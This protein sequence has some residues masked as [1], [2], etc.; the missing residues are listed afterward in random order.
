MQSAA[1]RAELVLQSAR[2][3]FGYRVE[4]AAEAVGDLGAMT[5]QGEQHR[6]EREKEKYE[7]ISTSLPLLTQIR[8]Q[9][10]EDVDGKQQG[11]CADVEGSLDE[12]DRDLR[13]HSGAR[14]F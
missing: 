7:D 13:R 12:P 1:S 5:P 2:K 11:D 9:Y 10:E 14:T 3:G 8:R 4:N 6:N